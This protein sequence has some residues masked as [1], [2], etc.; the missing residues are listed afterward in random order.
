MTRAGNNITKALTVGERVHVSECSC[1]CVC[2]CVC[3]ST[4]LDGSAATP[5]KPNSL[6]NAYKHTLGTP[7]FN[8][9][10]LWSSL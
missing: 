1:V 8:T 5:L 9:N 10:Q 3:V 6:Q 7:T 4:G 2:V